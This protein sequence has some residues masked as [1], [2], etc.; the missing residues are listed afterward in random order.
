MKP[1]LS[2]KPASLF[3]IAVL[4]LQMT[5]LCEAHAASKYKL[6]D[7][8]DLMRGGY[9]D[10]GG[11]INNAGEIIFQSYLYSNGKLL[12][13]SSLTKAEITN[14]SGIN[15]TGEVIG[16]AGGIGPFLY[17]KG[18]VTQLDPFFL[19]TPSD[20]NDAK[21]M[22]GFKDQQAFLYNY[23]DNTM[24]LLG[25]PA[26]W[27]ESS[28]IAINNSAQIAGT[29]GS[30]RHDDYLSHAFL[31]SA[32]KMLDLGSLR[33]GLESSV[34]TAINDAGQVTGRSGNRAFLYDGDTMRAIG[35]LGAGSVGLGINSLGHVT[36]MSWTTQHDRRAFLYDEDAMIDLNSV[37]EPSSGAGWTLTE[38]RDI[39]D[40]GQILA[41]GFREGT[42][43]VGIGEACHFPDVPCH[44]LLLTPVPEPSTYSL[45]IA[46]ICLIALLGP[47][48]MR[49]R[50]P[51][52]AQ[53]ARVG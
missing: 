3:G 17:S 28:G 16:M 41:I 49:G 8:G 23:S 1:I 24:T 11:A 31:Y 5:A 34:A 39:N 9:Y 50:R 37:M 45:T 33:G 44:I 32:G 47:W 14:A 30:Y 36:G 25:T 2:L 51:F 19:G 6:T 10:Y 43:N 53:A 27:V 7:L 21:Q 46:G 18:I 13:L 4:V 35:T 29:L 26:G 42:G 22:T 20:I 48:R 15:N 52:R 40:S 38:G 12:D